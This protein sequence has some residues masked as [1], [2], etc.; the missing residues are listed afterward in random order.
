MKIVVL[1]GHTLNPGDLS[2]EHLEALGDCVVHDR[3]TPA[4][5]LERAAEATAV[6]T[7][8]APLTGKLIAALPSLKYIGVTATGFNVVDVSAAQTHG[9]TVTNVP[10]YGTRSVAQHAI[11]LLLELTNH[12]GRNAVAVS[13]GAWVNARDWCFSEAGITELDQLTLGIVGWGRI[14][15]ATAEIARA[16]G[17]EILAS[18]RTP[19]DSEEAVEFVSVDELFRRS[20]IISLHCPLT[21]ETEGLVDAER[22]R[23]MK[24]TARLINTSRG[25]LIDE[26]ALAAALNEDRIAGAG[27]DVLSS[28]PP[29]AANPLLS[30]KNCLI[31]AHNAWASR[32]ARQRLLNVSAENLRAFQ[33]GTPQNVVS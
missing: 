12:V 17:M 15:E 23:L 32:A 30:A 13:N 31:T 29:A 16:L 9:I 10:A 26:A 7:N 14:G 3:S 24:R 8:K 4:Q 11:A 21:A 27:L 33:S 1:D 2:W 18:S 6:I 5:T 19:R 22:L 25:Q 20:D 28:E